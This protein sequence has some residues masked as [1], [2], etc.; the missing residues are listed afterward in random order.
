M[1]KTIALLLALLLVAVMLPVTAMAAEVKEV[2]TEGELTA[3][4]EA[5]SDGDT[6]KLIDN[7]EVSVRLVINKATTLDLNSKALTST[8][9]M[10]SD[11][12][13]AERYALVNNAVL[14]IKNGFFN[15]GQARG[16]GAYA[17]LTMD[18][19]KVKQALTGGHACLALC[20][21]GTT[22]SIM[23][24][25]IDGAYAVSCFADNATVNI[26]SSNIIGT[27]ETLYHNGSNYGLKLTV[28]NTTISGNGNGCGVY[29]SGSKAAQSN[30][31]NQNGVGGYQKATFTNCTISGT[32]GV[33]VKYTDL[34]LDNCKVSTTQ[35]APSYTQNNNGPAASGFA[36]VSTDNAMNETTPVP[37][38]AI[39]IKGN[40][41]DYDGL[42]GL[43]TLDSVRSDYSGF[44]TES[45]EVSGGTFSGNIKDYTGNNLVIA[46]D[47]GDFYVGGTAQ[48]TLEN[49]NAND[50]FH[51]E[52]A[53]GGKLDNV[54]AG[55]T[56]IN[57][58]SEPLT[59]NGETYEFEEVITV[60]PKNATI[61]IIQPTE[62]KPAEDQKNP[63]TGA[64]DFVGIAAAMAIVS[65]VGAAAVSRKK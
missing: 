50:R 23:N 19:V 40:N 64:N 42:V 61:V 26:A 24:S 34:T 2:S 14:T 18:G 41:G 36:V 17:A 15:V 10:P 27:G 60:K 65:V 38:G 51:V 28:S 62:D 63:S 46:K 33:E 7:I 59:V 53:P 16:I 9:A 48:S 43:G 21:N 8:W 44:T 45:I 58:T 30:A 4:I 6:I 32:N 47:G 25:T 11:A 52:N 3:A 12:S 54:A 57:N 56:L 22:Y 39:T 29:I 20:A 37:E 1:K 49:A 55:V 13:G 31:A 35:S 5:A